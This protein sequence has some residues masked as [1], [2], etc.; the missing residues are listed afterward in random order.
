MAGMGSSVVGLVLGAVLGAGT[1]LALLPF[2]FRALDKAQEDLSRD[3]TLPLLVHGG[4]WAACGLA[5]GAAFAIGLG[6]GRIRLIKAAVGGLIGAVFGAALYE[7]I[8]ATAFPTDKTTY[9]L[10]TIWIA[11]LLARLL[12]ATLSGLLAAVVINTAARRP[13]G[14]QR[15]P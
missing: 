1:S 3:L 15:T 9:P 4:I 10:A 11:R 6:A 13:L 5:G 12:V 7:L 14:W 8:G 2:Y